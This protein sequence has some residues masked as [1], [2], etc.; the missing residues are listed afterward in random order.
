MTRAGA[1]SILKRVGYVGLVVNVRH[2]TLVVW[3]HD[4]NG[5]SVGEPFIQAG[6]DRLAIHEGAALALVADVRRVGRHAAE[7]QLEVAPADTL[8]TLRCAYQVIS[9]ERCDFFGLV[10]RYRSR[11]QQVVCTGHEGAAVGGERRGGQCSS[12]SVF[13]STHMAHFTKQLAETRQTGLLT[14]LCR[15]PAEC[16][17]PLLAVPLDSHCAVGFEN[18]WRRVKSVFYI[19]I[20]FASWLIR[21]ER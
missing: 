20:I 19:E 7:R 13:V 10:E 8:L 21:G 4:R 15:R 16:D 17:I 18:E 2:V 11:M 1:V 3:I 5:A 12:A 9:S 14:A 6:C